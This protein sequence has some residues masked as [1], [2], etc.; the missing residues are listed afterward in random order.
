MEAIAS[1]RSRKRAAKQTALLLAAG[2]AIPMFASAVENPPPEIP[3]RAPE[4]PAPVSQGQFAVQLCAFLQ[5]ATDESSYR[6]VRDS[7]DIQAATPQDVARAVGYLAAEGLI[8]YRGWQPSEPLRRH[9]VTSLVVRA[10]RA[11]DR[12]DLSDPDACL[13]FAESQEC[14]P[15]TVLDAIRF[16][17]NRKK[18]LDPAAPTP[19]R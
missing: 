12:L 18:N 2:L 11:E 7:L 10:C 4:A 14:D 15:S 19:D 8:P 3:P 9:D 6:A 17:W 1:S 16:I 13:A 5:R